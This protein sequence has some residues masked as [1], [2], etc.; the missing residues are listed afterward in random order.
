VR[1]LLAR[2]DTLVD[3]HIALHSSVLHIDKL[4]EVEE[5]AIQK[6]DIATY[7]AEVGTAFIVG[8]AGRMHHVSG[9]NQ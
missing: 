7:E 2:R 8:D 1:I 6:V 4:T 3:I 5:G 9:R